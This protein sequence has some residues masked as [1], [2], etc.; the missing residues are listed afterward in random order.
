[1]QH[2][3]SLSTTLSRNTYIDVTRAIAIIL[4]VI[5][6]CI[7]YGSGIEFYE[8]S[9]FFAQPLFKFIYSFHMPLFMLI[10][11][12]LCRYS[13]T[14]R[15]IN[16]FIID[17]AKGVLLPLIS[18]HT[19]YQIL[20]L[21]TGYQNI[22]AEVFIL[23]YFHTLW[24]LRAL[25]VCYIINF[26]IYKWGHDHLSLY[27]TLILSLPFISNRILP[28]VF[29][30]TIPFFFAGYLYN[31]YQEKLSLIRKLTES[32][33]CYLIVIAFL[34]LLLYHYKNEYYV[35]I[36]K[37]YLFNPELSFRFMAF[38]NLFRNLTAVVGCCFILLTIKYCIDSIPQKILTNILIPIGKASLCIY[39]LNHYLNDILLIHLPIQKL[40]YLLI[41]AESI[42]I[43]GIGYIL[44]NLLKKIKTLNQLFLGGR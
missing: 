9:S 23:S 26:L 6:H 13:I 36:T 37:T 1:M 42:L 35:Y 22:S 18:W 28:D 7:Q 15:N 17:K 33:I 10:S 21:S 3:K 44:A 32:R 39:I 27:I 11:G 30:F 2:E 19:L 38:V 4:V 41:M 5:G 31:K 40:N 16:S 25:F 24:F 12:Y 14:K 20:L 43:I 8:S 29:V 34:S